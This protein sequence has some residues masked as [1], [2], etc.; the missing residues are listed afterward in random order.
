MALPS[1]LRSTTI[2]LFL[3][4]T[5]LH[6]ATHLDLA[7]LLA[8]KTTSDTSNKLTSWTT[9]TSN[10]CHTTPPFHGVTCLHNRVTMLVLERLDLHGPFDSLTSL[11][12]LRVLSLKY[13]QLTGPIPNLSNLTSLKLVFLSHNNFSGHFPSPLPSLYRLDL[14]YNNISGN[15]P[16]TV[17]SLNNLLTLRLE[18]NNFSGYISF[19]N[20]TSLNDFNISK[21]NVSGEIPDSL[22]RFPETVF[23]N[24]PFLCDIRRSKCGTRPIVPSTAAVPEENK[25]GSSGGKISKI[26][27]IAIIIGDVLV[28]LLVSLLLYCY[29]A[30]KTVEKNVV[31]GEKKVVYRNSDEKGRMVFLDGGRRFELDDLLRASAETLGRGGLGTAYKAVLDDGGVVVVKRLKEVVVGGGGKKEFEEK[32]DVLGR[33]KHDNI[34]SL[35]AYYFAKDEK[36]LVYD[37]MSNGNLFWLLHGNRGPGRTPLDWS[38]RLKI[39]A[40]AATGLA[41]IHNSGKLT[42]GNIKSTNILLDNS[43]NARVSDFSLSAITPP[44]AAQRSAGYRAPELSSTTNNRKI[45]QKSDVYS[46]GVLLMELLTGKCPS[47]MENDGG[48]V[49]LPQWVRSVVRE[50]WTAEV[51]DLEL[52]SYK[53]IEEEMVVLLNIAISCTV[54]GPNQRPVMDHVVKMIHDIQGV[55]VSPR[56]DTLNLDIDSPSVIATT[57]SFSYHPN[58]SYITPVYSIFSGQALAEDGMTH[59]SKP[60]GFSPSKSCDNRVTSFLIF[61]F[62]ESWTRVDCQRVFEKYGA[63]KDVYFARKRLSSGHRF[64]YV[65]FEG[66]TEIDVR[67]K[68]AV[69]HPFC[70]NHENI[71]NIDGFEDF[72]PAPWNQN[73]NRGQN[74]GQN[75]SFKWGDKSFTD[76]IDTNK[77]N[78][79]QFPANNHIEIKVGGKR[80]EFNLPDSV[81]N[82]NLVFSFNCDRGR[83]SIDEIPWHLQ[84]GKYEIVECGG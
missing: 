18:E 14:S 13:N 35:K 46:F 33:L 2:L 8:F 44:S 75:N 10:P 43:G 5:L 68:A 28:L 9:N 64:G 61:N 38:T 67:E 83:R 53:D 51:F 37:Y 31:E 77:S 19:L 60:Y 1:H 79:L 63:L 50:E 65:R 21:N 80:H 48:V 58:Q 22:S 54:S 72:P 70:S 71:P 4:L 7:A 40:G 41:F 6:A 11:V 29:F 76:A 47:T 39:A 59:M 45:T 27:V 69:F 36:L 49:D 55:E 15:I 17:N 25:E 12:K 26:A 30:G 32:M 73:Q 24:N 3:H 34:V 84:C 66:I 16:V 62:P 74:Q 82:H 20:L 52:M 78:K 42:H 23:S 56:S 81:S 57:I